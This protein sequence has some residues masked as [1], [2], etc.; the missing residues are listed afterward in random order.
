MSSDPFV[1]ALDATAVA[2]AKWLTEV[3]LGNPHCDNFRKL[4]KFCDE[5]HAAGFLHPPRSPPPTASQLTEWAK[6]TY[7][8]LRAMNRGSEHPYGFSYRVSRF[9]DIGSNPGGFAQFI[10][11]HSNARGVGVSLPIDSGGIGCAIPPNERFELHE[12][13]ILDLV[14]SYLSSRVLPFTCD[15]F[16]LIILDAN[17]FCP[18]IL[19]AQLLL[20]LYTIYNG[21]QI[22]LT[23]SCIE[24][25]F[26]ARIVLALK[27]IAYN[28]TTSKPPQ[29]SSGIFYIH[30]QAVRVDTPAYRK[31]KDNLTRLWNQTHTTD[32]REPT[33]E[34]Q[35][36]IT[37]WDE[38]MKKSN[39]NL[40]AKL[41]NPLWETQLTALNRV[42]NQTD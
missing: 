21:G 34:E 33:W 39:T 4:K 30:A 9:L 38:V 12:L 11:Q 20:A 41:G 14:S 29:A 19:L 35:D 2:E 7:L 17:P 40:I 10:L 3:L 6:N 18:R 31:L 16:D 25:P 13:D 24:R 15:K 8:M 32:T 23:L 28:I 36:L 27:R 5:I 42:F 1:P 37:L 26:T 22:L